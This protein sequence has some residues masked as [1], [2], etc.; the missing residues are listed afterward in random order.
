MRP[1]KRDQDGQQDLLRSRLDQIVDL[2]HP[3]A[4]LARGI[5]WSFL[6][7]QL[8]A[9]YTD[10]PGRPPL[11]TRLTAGLA[12]LK[13]AHDLSDEVLCE[14]WLE[15]RITNCSAAK[16][17]LPYAAVRPLVDDP[18]A[19]SGCGRKNCSLCCRRGC[20]LPPAAAL[21]STPTSTPGDR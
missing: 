10:R 4:K 16:I 13:H 18:L 11:P 19:P 6:E 15:N 17:L 21:P 20:T 3:L 1:T 14:R 9:V 8:G 12:I 2:Q 7:R 5:D